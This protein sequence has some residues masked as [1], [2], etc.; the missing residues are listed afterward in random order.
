[1]VGSWAGRRAAWRPLAAFALV[2]ALGATGTALVESPAGAKPAHSWAIEPGANQGTDTN[3]LYGVSCLSAT[4]CI[5]VGFSTS[6]GVDRTLVESWNGTAWKIEPSVDPGGVWNFLYGVSCSTDRACA[7]VGRYENP[8]GVNRTLIEMW[9]GTAWRLVTS[10]NRDTGPSVLSAVSCVK[11]TFCVAVGSSQ[12]GGVTRALI[13]RWNGKVWSIDAGSANHKP[14][15]AN[16]LAGVTC[17]SVTSCTAVGTF[18]DPHGVKHA[19]VESWNGTKWSLGPSRDRGTLGTAL[20]GVACVSAKW[21]QAVGTYDVAVAGKR[22]VP[23][24][25]VESWNGAKWLVAPSPNRDAGANTL[26]AVSCISAASCKAVG[27]YE[28][29]NAPVHQTLTVAWD[30]KTWRIVGSPNPVTSPVTDNYLGVRGSALNAVSCVSATM[31]R[32]AGFAVDANGHD[33]VLIEAFS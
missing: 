32:S 25:L 19:L 5:A 21:C 16:A 7:A 10:P 27:W 26:A 29:H 23:R 4:A 17:T 18:F 31:C 22:T 6:P 2:A 8:S 9:N 12:A 11:A 1:M 28:T 33:Q 30:G 3:F 15:S 13:E 14:A 24:T 20:T